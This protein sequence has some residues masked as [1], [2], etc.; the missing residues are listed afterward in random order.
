MIPSIVG[1][2]ETQWGSVGEGY[3]EMVSAQ[4]AGGFEQSEPSIAGTVYLD[5]W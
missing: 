1:K 5:R 4:C 3:R 2:Q